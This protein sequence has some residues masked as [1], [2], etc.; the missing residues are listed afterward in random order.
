M[1]PSPIFSNIKTGTACYDEVDK[2]SYKGISIKTLL[3]FFLTTVVAVGVTIIMQW[4]L[5]QDTSSE[6][7]KRILVISSVGAIVSIIVGFIAALVGRISPK[8][9]KICI[10]I[11]SVAEGVCIGFITGIIEAALPGSNVGI[12]A[13]F[14]TVIVFVVMLL[15]Y[16]FGIIRV[17][18]FVMRFMLALLLCALSL[19]LFTLIYVLVVGFNTTYL[20]F[21]ITIEAIYLIY[22]CLMLTLNFQEASDVV[23]SG[24]TKDA[25]WSV[26]LGLLISLAYIYFE[27]LRILVLLLRIFGNRN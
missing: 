24:C 26:A 6:A 18:S 27:L 21:V 14:G 23:K 9:A 8:K 19:A 13:A 20:G 2:A 7:A 5:K 16:A 22:A 11:Y 17:N 4:A 1:K 3:F 15:L 25:E 10:G 12:L